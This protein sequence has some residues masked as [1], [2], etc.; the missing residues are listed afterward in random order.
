MKKIRPA[1]VISSDAV[2][3]LPIKLVAPFTDWK[4]YF[5]SNIWHVKLVPDDTNGLS[6]TSAVDVLQLRGL[7]LSRFIHRLGYLSEKT[8][9]KISASIIA[10]VEADI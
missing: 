4:P 3:K 6:K 10:V 7:D 9:N 2:G 1:I 8:M 5:S